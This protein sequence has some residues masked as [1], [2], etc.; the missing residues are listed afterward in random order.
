[1]EAQLI[2]GSQL[3]IVET[4]ILTQLVN[5]VEELRK[6]LSTLSTTHKLFYTNSEVKALLGVGDK[7]IKKYRDEGLL[8]YT[9][10]SDKFWYSMAD[11][12][13]FMQANYF[14]PFNLVA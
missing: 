12:Q 11:I 3:S 14:S 13:K 7:L 5:Q 2:S 10:V 4:S 8:G 6:Q 1:M 9:Q